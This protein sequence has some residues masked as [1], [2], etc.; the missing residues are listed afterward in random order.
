M[1]S[2]ANPPKDA[3]DNWLEL[4]P[5]RRKWRLDVMM[6]WFCRIF[7]RYTRSFDDLPSTYEPS[8]WAF[9]APKLRTF[10]GLVYDHFNPSRPE[11]Q[12]YGSAAYHFVMCVHCEYDDCLTLWEWAYVSDSAYTT[13]QMFGVLV[14]VLAFYYSLDG[15]Y[16]MELDP[17]TNLI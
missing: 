16:V 8:H 12:L 3:R 4:S 13:P 7:R 6:D 9:A 1:S 14:R 11:L 5:A 2:D 10:L 15:F 17:P